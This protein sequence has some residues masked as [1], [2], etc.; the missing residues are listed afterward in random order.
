MYRLKAVCNIWGVRFSP[1]AAERSTGLTFSDRNEPFEIGTR[2]RYANR[3][4]PYGAAT[5]DP[6]ST[7]GASSNLDALLDIVESQVPTLRVLGAEEIVLH[8]DVFHDG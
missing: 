8:C 6:E 7:G 5:L 3:P 1:S 4:T 2:G